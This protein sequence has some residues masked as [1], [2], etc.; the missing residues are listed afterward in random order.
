[1]NRIEGCQIDRIDA[2]ASR[3]WLCHV[4]GH[5]ALPAPLGS[6][7]WLLCHCDD[8]VTWGCLD[9]G[10][11][12]LGSEV[13]SEVCPVPSEINIQELRL[14]SPTCE[15][16]IWRRETEL[17]GRILHDGAPPLLDSPTKPQY[18]ERLLLG[19]RVAET[20]DGFTR[21]CDGTGFGQ[22]LPPILVHGRYTC[23]SILAVRH[24]FS[25]DKDSGC[26][27]VAATRLVE[28]K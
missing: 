18:E 2:A 25:Q 13:F 21:V 23:P 24:Y 6:P 17:R 10:V 16:L 15:V 27:R 11:W 4:R 19:G 14:F 7:A 22:V 9:G 1:M 3:A 8:G 28:V 26:V 12:R 20:R 5:G